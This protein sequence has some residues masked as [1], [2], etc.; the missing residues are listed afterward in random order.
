MFHK[1]TVISGSWGP[2]RFAV[3]VRFLRSLSCSLLELLL[4]FALFVYY[5][6]LTKDVV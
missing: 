2:P 5:P 3:S 1:A 4:V 6:G